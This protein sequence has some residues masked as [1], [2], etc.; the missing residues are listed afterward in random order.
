MKIPLLAIVDE[1]VEYVLKTKHFWHS[2]IT[3]VSLWSF[4]DPVLIVCSFGKLK[5]ASQM[6]T[7][8]IQG[9][10][11]LIWESQGSFIS[12]W[13][14]QIP[15]LLVITYTTCHYFLLLID[16]THHNS[17]VEPRGLRIGLC[18]GIFRSSNWEICFGYRDPPYIWK[19]IGSSPA[20]AHSPIFSVGVFAVWESIWVGKLFLSYH[21][22]P[23]SQSSDEP[24]LH[25]IFKTKFSVLLFDQEL[26]VL[27]NYV[28][29][30][31]LELKRC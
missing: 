31:I 20:P 24:N 7:Q 1:H 26:S 6:S 13:I 21:I 15:L 11:V 27:I 25:P 16:N 2:A 28:L 14:A 23:Y 5:G 3:A 9:L 8:L 19:V 10:C 30:R 4:I 22:P 12:E 17:R 29:Q 18:G